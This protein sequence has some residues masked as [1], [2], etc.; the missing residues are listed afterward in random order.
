MGCRGHRRPL[1]SCSTCSH[2]CF[3]PD[4]SR[5]YLVAGVQ[6]HC[7]DFSG[8]GH[9]ISPGDSSLTSPGMGTCCQCPLLAHS[10]PSR[11]ATD[12]FPSGPGSSASG[13]SQGR[14]VVPWPHPEERGLGEPMQG[15]VPEL[16]WGLCPAPLVQGVHCPSI[17]IPAF[18]SFWDTCF[19]GA[20]VLGGLVWGSQ[21]IL[22]CVWGCPQSGSCW[23]PALCPWVQGRAAGL[24]LA[25]EGGEEVHPRDVRALV[26]CPQQQEG[27]TGASECF[28][29]TAPSSF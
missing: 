20:A 9:V 27:S 21:W 7:Q 1:A 29:P 17:P 11:L 28:C 14:G 2:W 13:V 24:V 15:S 6:E 25:W 22:V 8:R 4:G 3:G 10:L 16:R 5:R 19:L 12:F 23:G 26:L 18:P